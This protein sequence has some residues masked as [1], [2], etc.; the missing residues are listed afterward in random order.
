VVTVK[1]VCHSKHSGR[2]LDEITPAGV[3]GGEL[4]V[5]G[6]IGQRLRVITGHEGT[7]QSILF[8]QARQVKFQDQVPTQLM[9]LP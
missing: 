2:P 6:G 9:V 5:P 8:F 4:P 7:Q 3:K 1:A